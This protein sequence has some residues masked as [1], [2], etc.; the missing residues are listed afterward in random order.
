MEDTDEPP[1]PLL[2][3][4]RQAAQTLS[5]G[6]TTVYELIAEG[7]LGVIHIG[8]AVRVPVTAVTEFVDRRVTAATNRQ[9]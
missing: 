2:L 9:H 5:I 1:R 7:E 4:V 8:R 3:T 6:R